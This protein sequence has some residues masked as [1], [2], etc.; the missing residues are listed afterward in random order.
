[1]RP[2]GRP[3][4]N[5]NHRKDVLRS[6][7]ELFASKGFDATSIRDIAKA[8]GVQPS[9]VYYHF[10]SKDALLIAVVEPAAQKLAAKV[11]T[12]AGSGDPWSR[13]EKACAAHLE[14]LLHGQG[15]ARVVAMEI[16]SR[17]SGALQTA[18]VQSRDGYEEIFRRLVA[19]LP[20]P[21]NVDR[22]YFRLSLLGAIN[23]ALIWYRPGRDSTAS[24]ARQIIR[25][26]RD[27]NRT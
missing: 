7:T 25:V 27:A 26:F 6:A 5:D 15:V 3:R 21:S 22:R 16:P 1:V 9:S 2:V 17:R 24:V 12:A 13:L 10:P 23:W 4:S 8:A 20:L 14:L 11:A 19:E 18:L